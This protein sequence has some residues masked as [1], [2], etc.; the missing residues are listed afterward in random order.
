ML[1]T[2]RI[3]MGRRNRLAAVILNIKALYRFLLVIFHKT[4][5]VQIVSL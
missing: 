1:N 5:T 2:W 4:D 3:G